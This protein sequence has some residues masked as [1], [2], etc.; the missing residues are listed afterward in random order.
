M[1]CELNGSF[2]GAIVSFP[3]RATPSGLLFIV[4]LATHCFQF[5]FLNSI[6]LILHFLIKKSTSSL[7]WFTHVIQPLGMLKQEDFKVKHSLDYLR[8]LSD[9]TNK[10]KKTMK[11]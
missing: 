3:A 6:G 9:K 5:S 8:R 7:Q 1:V 2:V 4:I 10:E 11:S